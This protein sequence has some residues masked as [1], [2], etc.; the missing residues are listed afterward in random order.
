MDSDGE[1]CDLPD[2]VEVLA[3]MWFT[4]GLLTCE[5]SSKGVMISE[6]LR[7]AKV[8]IFEFFLIVIG[9]L[10]GFRILTGMLVPEVVLRVFAIKRPN[11]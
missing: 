5:G 8:P 3:L 4:C 1:D 10:C 2:C 9:V 11:D 7:G 6:A